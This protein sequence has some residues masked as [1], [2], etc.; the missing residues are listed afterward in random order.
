MQKLPIG[1]ANLLFVSN[2]IES[3]LPHAHDFQA[4]AQADPI[5]AY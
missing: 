1:N 4:I 5:N 3:I 2:S